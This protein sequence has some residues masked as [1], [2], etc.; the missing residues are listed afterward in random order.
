VN[1]VHLGSGVKSGWQGKAQPEVDF[2]REQNMDADRGSQ[3][4]MQSQRWMSGGGV[5]DVL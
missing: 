1:L 5:K 2:G 3:K 4:W